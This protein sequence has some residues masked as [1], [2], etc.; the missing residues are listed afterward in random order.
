M[1]YQNKKKFQ[2]KKDLRKSKDKKIKSK[3]ETNRIH[4]RAERETAR[5]S[6]KY[7]ERLIP[8]RKIKDETES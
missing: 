1:D 6:Y 5:L 4:S 7:R 3:R 8:I 2:K